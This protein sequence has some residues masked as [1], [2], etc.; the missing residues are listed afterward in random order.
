MGIRKLSL[1]CRM[2]SRSCRI[3]PFLWV[4]A[5]SC[6]L[7]GRANWQEIECVLHRWNLFAYHMIYIHT[8]T[9]VVPISSRS[10]D[11][12]LVFFLWVRCIY[13]RGRGRGWGE[14]IETLRV[15]FI[16]ALQPFVGNR[17]RAIASARGMLAGL[18]HHRGGN[19]FFKARD[20]WS[21]W[22]IHSSESECPL[23]KSD[24]LRLLLFGRSLAT[25]TVLVSRQGSR[26]SHSRHSE[27][28]RT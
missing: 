24:R 8:Y 2:P 14:K 9:G 3:C 10:G 25:V 28:S 19:V 5:K 6:V 20:H 13:L 18:G 26:T 12:S 7:C 15:F 21:W 23:N 11:P 4:Y 1:L 22:G 27:G 17:N 16:G